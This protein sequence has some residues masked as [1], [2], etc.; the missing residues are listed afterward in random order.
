MEPFKKSNIIK[1]VI[2]AV[3][4]LIAILILA[5]IAYPIFQNVQSTNQQINA[6]KQQETAL[7]QRLED[8]KTLEN[9]YNSAKGKSEPTVS[10]ALPTEK[11]IPEILVQLENIAAENSM[12]FQEIT[13]TNQTSATPTS[14]G[15]Q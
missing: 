5:F 3:A 10:L 14:S 2:L 13:A 15:T 8:L 11:Q 6:K 12:T 9:N 4:I 1:A 7:E